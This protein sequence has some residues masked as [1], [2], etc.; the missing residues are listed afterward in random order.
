[1]YFWLGTFIRGNSLTFLKQ[2]L[3]FLTRIYCAPTKDIN[4]SNKWWHCIR[5]GNCKLMRRIVYY[6]QCLVKSRAVR[7]HLIWRPDERD[8]VTFGPW[9]PMADQRSPFHVVGEVPAGQPSHRHGLIDSRLLAQTLEQNIKHETTVR[10][11]YLISSNAL[12]L[13]LGCLPVS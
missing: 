2:E 9:Q 6:K 13:R 7:C 5:T 3:K 11:L 1:M 10:L 8:N 4:G 12:T